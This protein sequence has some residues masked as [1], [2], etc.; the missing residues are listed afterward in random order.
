[1]SFAFRREHARAATCGLLALLVADC[2]GPR[3]SEQAFQADT[4]GRVFAVAFHGIYDKYVDPVSMDVIADDALQQLSSLDGDLMVERDD[5]EVRLLD[6]G[7]VVERAPAPD[8]DDP[9]GWARATT[10]MVTAAEDRSR[11]LASAPAEDVYRVMLRGALHSLDPL[12]RYAD[13]RQARAQRAARDGF[14][15]IGAQISVNGRGVVISSVTRDGPAARAALRA[16][17][18]IL[19]IDG[20]DVRKLDEPAVLDR[21]RGRPG[22]NV[23]L[24][25][26]PTGASGPQE[27]TLTRTAIIPETVRLDM[28]G[29]VALIKVSSF[30]QGTARAL[31]VSIAD[32]RRRT[33]SRF[34]G[35]ILDMRN[36]P[37][38]LLDQAVAVADLFLSS[39]RII[40]TRGRHPDSFQLFDA[41]G[42]DAAAGAPIVVLMDGG[43]ASSSEVVAAAL[44]DRGRAVVVGSNSYGKGT[45]QN[46]I[47]L[48]N[49]GELAITW[50]RLYAPSGYTFDGLGILP[51]VCT[52][53]VEEDGN[54]VLARIARGE[55]TDALRLAAWR[56]A[57]ELDEAQRADLAR[58][59]PKARGDRT[60]DL[61][62]ARGL[63]A[64]KNLYA[65]AL[66]LAAP[67]EPP[68]EA[69]SA[70]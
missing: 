65:K 7:R 17:D 12:S 48:P 68:V 36:N 52:S 19:T 32:A 59:C 30:N 27:V 29:D 26:T 3:R 42:G 34:G 60:A 28:I 6:R 14:G 33:G 35:I 18:I 69:A 51:N 43:S 47:R 4:G 70:P 5:Q 40:S 45:V 67:V 53:A 64:Q 41:T 39:G 24:S 16:G 56:T 11:V 63:L 38:G 31:A 46:I 54:A 55:I 2:A 10:R 49:D 13:A 50:S 62:V 57:D 25:L 37:G 66:A 9:D 15:G 61:D 20:E 23:R 21:L 58:T 22:T 44:Q 8:E 1:M